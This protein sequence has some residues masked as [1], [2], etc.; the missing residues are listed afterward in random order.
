MWY[1]KLEKLKR[2]ELI[3][4]IIF[5]NFKQFLLDL[6]KNSMNHQSH[7]AQLH[8]NAKQESQQSIQVFAL[9]LKNLKAH[10]SSIMKKHHCS[11]LFTK[12]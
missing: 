4:K 5:K 8:Q 11:I 7:H 9:Y 3:K 1:N 2:P 6:V 12:L 10:I